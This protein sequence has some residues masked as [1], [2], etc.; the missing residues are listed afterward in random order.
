MGTFRH[1]ALF[2]ILALVLKCAGYFLFEAFVLGNGAVAAVRSIP[3]NVIQVT[4]AAA[5]V[6]VLYRPLE[7]GLRF[8]IT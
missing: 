1:I 4:V 5:I 8:A 3:G 6:L 7:K 2:V